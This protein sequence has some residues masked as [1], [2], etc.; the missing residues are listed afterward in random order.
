MTTDAQMMF[1]ATSAEAV[2]ADGGPTVA[3]TSAVAAAP[4]AEPGVLPA[5]TQIV[6]LS[7]LRWDFVYQRPQHLMARL[8]RRHRVLYVEEPVPT[9]APPHLELRSVAPNIEVV[10]P[11]LPEAECAVGNPS[12][13]A[14]QR[15]LLAQL[16]EARSAS[17]RLLLWYYTPMACGI[18]GAL[19]PQWVVYD[20]MDELAAFHQPPPGL[21]ARE[22]QLLA[23]ADLVFTGGHS[24]YES[25]RRRHPRVHLFPSSVDV[26]HF[27]RARSSNHE[28]VEMRGLPHPRIGFY[29]VVDER[30]DIA[31][32]GAVARLR[33]QWQ[34]VVVGPV[35]KID[36]ASLPQ[37]PNLHYVG[38]RSYAELPDYLGSWDVAM[39]PFALNASTRFIS[40][41]KTPE[42]LAA[43][44]PVVSTPVPDVV[45]AYGGSGLVGIAGDA[46]A[47]CAAVAKA[48]D[49]VG[50]HRA[51][52]CA[53]A[54]ALLRGL[55]WDRTCE[56]M[57]A[58]AAA[59]PSQRPGGKRLTAS[60][61]PVPVPRERQPSARGGGL[62]TV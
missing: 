40:P 24:L 2:G 36:P 38:L 45:R 37:A 33:P 28:P 7:H 17:S 13:E 39:M 25:K 6:C 44:R 56:Q 26:A 15:V 61:G 9:D 35:V 58:L 10:V 34:W 29:G 27:R 41:T 53:K 48:L 18:T 60:A 54:D 21:V 3:A 1:S 46:V 30:F 62:S 43:G 50:E 8:A 5:D 14:R 55:S 42:F 51:E 32:L 11:R 16:I 49:D 19:S 23:E 31:L 12:G 22:R 57:V 47:F 59:L 20:V 4:P 52:F